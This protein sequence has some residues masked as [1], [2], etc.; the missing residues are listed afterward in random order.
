MQRT[1][2]TLFILLLTTAA[3]SQTL[4]NNFGR[5]RALLKIHGRLY[6]DSTWTKPLGAV[7]IEVKL[8]TNRNERYLKVGENVKINPDFVP[9]YESLGKLKTNDQGQYEFYVDLQR[10]Y[11]VVFIKPS[12]RR[13]I[14]D[15]LTFTNSEAMSIMNKKWGNRIPEY[16]TSGSLEPYENG[17]VGPP[18]EGLTSKIMF[19]LDST[20]QNFTLRE[21]LQAKS[22][23]EDAN[24]MYVNRQRKPEELEERRMGVFARAEPVQDIV[25]KKIG[26]VYDSDT[27]NIVDSNL[28]RQGGWVYFG[29]ES[30]DDR[31]ADHHKV[32]E[33]DY[34]DGL[35]EQR[36]T[37]FFPNQNKELD[38]MFI[39]DRF[40][41][42]FTTYYET[43]EV[44]SRGSYD[45]SIK[46]KV[47]DFDLFYKQGNLKA[48]FQFDDT[49]RKN[50]Q[51]YVYYPN[52]NLA[53]S[54]IFLNDTLH[55]PM[56]IMEKSGK[57]LEQRIYE[58]GK[59]ISSTK[60]SDLSID[61]QLDSLISLLTLDSSD[62]ERRVERAL[63]ELDTIE[64]RY[65]SL[66]SE[67]MKE[68]EALRAQLSDSELSALKAQKEADRMKALSQLQ[69]EKLQR[70][71]LLIAA[72]S[73]ITLIILGLVFLLYRR[74][75]EK[76]R[77][78]AQLHEQ[79]EQIEEKNREITDSITYA[80]RLQDAI[81]PSLDS[82]QKAI[83]NSFVLYLPKDIVAGDFYWMEKIGAT[84]FF[85]AADCTGHGVPGAFV[86]VV[87]NNAL[88]RAVR[89]FELR[90][91]AQ[92]L[93][94]A[95]E[96]VTETFAKSS[97]DVKD[98]MDVSLC[99]LHTATNK[100][101]WAGA[102]NPLW[103]I[104][105]NEL[106]EI[107]ADKQP[108]GK[109]HARTPYQNHTIRLKSGDSLYIFSDG[110]PDQFG[111]EKGKKY[112]YSNFKSLLQSL[113]KLSASEQRAS[114]E[115]EFEQWKGAH[116]Q[117]D[118]VCIIGFKV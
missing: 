105:Q 30:D 54:A 35:K 91:P 36:W 88:N 14:V 52:G 29:S 103:I 82:F 116:E 22:M 50:G 102:N 67:R 34:V 7:M 45:R 1:L 90:S 57:V 48:D 72:F 73:I 27:I 79:K 42:N 17:I 74:N 118:D 28:N 51:Q 64:E 16:S 96:I 93:D 15:V 21:E 12:Y 20:V 68:L 92:I 62:V 113:H 100:L 94:K 58:H 106:S 83:P 44:E 112:K 32:Y 66:L 107:K 114:L 80:K 18:V 69:E 109:H 4:K 41:G 89:E 85:A 49:G 108:I 71:R 2:T 40:N 75:E 37:R 31:F 10:E 3:F 11:Q 81:M 97:E 56:L 23:E 60:Q 104:S 115:A 19:S 43:G 59:L 63:V 13:R 47:A 26:V 38:L 98:G 117:I 9:N 55:G 101:E 95:A 53:V 84:V 6:T 61:N 33:G 110:F 87:C 78:N 65:D 46:R 99:A 111:G 86:S 77:I 76:K 70:N 39:N 24:K 25:S 5:T 8:L